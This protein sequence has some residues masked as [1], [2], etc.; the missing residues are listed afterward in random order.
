M[1]LPS[2]FPLRSFIIQLWYFG[3]KS[4]RVAL[5]DRVVCRVT[6]RLDEFV[7]C[8]ES[9]V[10]NTPLHHSSAETKLATPLG[11]TFTW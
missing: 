10:T 11:M 3:E 8:V 4:T 6:A 1:Q 7:E 5:R 9:A 2:V